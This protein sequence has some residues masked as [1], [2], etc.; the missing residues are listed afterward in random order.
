MRPSPNLK[1]EWVPDRTY[2]KAGG[3]YACRC[4]LGGTDVKAVHD[5]IE[6]PFEIEEDIALYGTITGAVT[7]GSGFRLILHGTMGLSVI[8]CAGWHNG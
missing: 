6:G 2:R 4:L 8:S 1:L 7:L 5:S 3:R